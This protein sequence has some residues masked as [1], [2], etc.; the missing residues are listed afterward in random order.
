MYKRWLFA[1][2]RCQAVWRGA[3]WDPNAQPKET[4][5]VAQSVHKIWKTTQNKTLAGQ[6]NRSTE[7]FDNGKFSFCVSGPRNNKLSQV[8]IYLRSHRR[9]KRV[10]NKRTT[11]RDSLADS[12]FFTGERFST[13]RAPPLF[14]V[15]GGLKSSPSQYLFWLH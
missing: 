13:F 15:Q 1:N 6:G 3:T 7:N 4:G 9:V 11:E 14:Q 10:A 2:Y 8:T 5:K 12:N